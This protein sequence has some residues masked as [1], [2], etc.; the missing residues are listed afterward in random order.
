M[1]KVFARK[2]E[3]EL[4]ALRREFEEQQVQLHKSLEAVKAH[5]SEISLDSLT[6]KSDKLTIEGEG[7]VEG[8]RERDSEGSRK[9]SSASETDDGTLVEGDSEGDTLT[10]SDGK[11]M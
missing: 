9:S 6:S 5:D 1:P 10:M 3:K 4:L 11:D 8:E 2:F 7:E